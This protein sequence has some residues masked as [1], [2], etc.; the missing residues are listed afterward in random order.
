M[1]K[2]NKRHVI[3]LAESALHILQQW[4]EKCDG[5]RYAFDLV[6]ETLDLDDA[7]VLYK[8]R[9]NATKCITSRWMSWG[10]RLDFLSVFQCMRSDIRLRSLP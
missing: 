3:P 5:S 6:K 1:M 10:T 9:N 7:E 4:Q 8:A 2:T